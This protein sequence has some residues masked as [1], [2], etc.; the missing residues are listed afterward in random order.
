MN[1]EKEWRDIFSFV[2]DFISK[3]C[4][5][6]GPAIININ[7]GCQIDSSKKY[8]L[9]DL[10][11]FVGT[12]E[13]CKIKIFDFLNWMQENGYPI[14]DELAIK[15]KG[16]GETVWA[17]RSSK[18]KQKVTIPVPPKTKWH[19]IH[20]RIVNRT[21]IEIETP[22]KREPYHPDDL[23]FT[24]KIW[25]QFEQFAF[26][27]GHFPYRLDDRANIISRIE[28][29]EYIKA[30]KIDISRLR[31]VLKTAFPDVEGNPISNNKSKGYKAEF[32]ITEPLI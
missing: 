31:K 10:S 8:N 13:N 25:D 3:I 14:A 15:K 11:P 29:P 28:A 22:D 20:F 23:G 4:G 17:A 32:H 7:D 19:Q 12:F 5:K 1:Y 6:S 18:T 27:I 16:Y 21:R 2:D 30:E 26:K 9:S 24:P